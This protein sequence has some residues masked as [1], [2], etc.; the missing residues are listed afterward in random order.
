MRIGTTPTHVFCLPFTN[1]L[2]AEAEITYKQGGKKVLQK[3][4]EDCARNGKEI[5]VTLTQDETFLFEETGVVEIQLRVLTASGAALASEIFRVSP[6]RC[7]SDE[8]LL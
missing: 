4:L 8:V 5:S 7:L 1:E 6:E 3:H 2:I